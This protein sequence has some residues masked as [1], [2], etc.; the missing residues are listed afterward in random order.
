MIFLLLLMVVAAFAVVT[1]LSVYGA[2][3]IRIE[4]DFAQRMSPQSDLR[5]DLDWFTEKYRKFASFKNSKDAT[6]EQLRPVWEAVRGPIN[7]WPKDM[8]FNVENFRGLLPAYKASGAIAGTVDF[9]S[10]VQTQ[11]VGQALDELGG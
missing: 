8:G 1:G 6:A 3:G 11:Y 2:S 10:V 7:A 5:Q 9:D 4:A